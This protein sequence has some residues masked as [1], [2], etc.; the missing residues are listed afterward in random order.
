MPF[1]TQTSD[2]WG[3]YLRHNNRVV[4][5][6]LFD[7]GI[8]TF[9]SG[10]SN[11]T[12][13]FLKLTNV[14]PAMNGGFLRRWGVTAYNNTTVTTIQSPVR[15][16]FYNVP[17]DQSDPTNTTNTNLWIATD[18][19][20]FNTF[21]DTG[22]TYTGYGPTDFA[23][24]G[25]V[26]AL[27]SRQWFYY[28]NGVNAPRKVYPGYTTNNTDSLNGI[29][30][31]SVIGG[32]SS[33]Y[34]NWPSVSF[35]A[36]SG[37]TGWGYTSAPTV[38][39]SDIPGGSGHGCTISLTI[40]SN[41]AVIS[42][43]ITN[44]G[45][46]YTN[47]YA[48]VSA[49]PS[50]GTQA[51]ITLY[52]QQNSVASN[53]GSVLGAD[54]AGPMSFVVGRQ[55]G[56]A[57]QNSLTGHTSDVVMASDPYGNAITNLP[58]GPISGANYKALTE[59]YDS[60]VSINSSY[61]VYV[62]S[63]ST[64]GQEQTAGFT[65]LSVTV[66]VPGPSY[67]LD[68]QVDTVILLATSDGGD[69]GT[70]Y[71]VASIPLT[72]FTLTGGYYRYSY[73]DSLPDS[74]NNA[75]N[76]Y[77][78]TDT[79][80]ASNLW[81]ETDNTGATYGI[82]L[83]TPP[84]AAGFLYPTLHQGRMF[85]TDGKTVF[86]SKSLDEV[87]TS[88]GLITCKWEECWPGDYQLPVA[89]D[90]E[91]ILGLK[92]DGTNL[93]IG[94]DK[95]IFTLYGSDPSNFDIPS[96]AFA[97]T[98]I[99]SN[100]CWTVI[101]AEGQPSGFVW[102]TQ[103]LK[104]IHSDFSTYR[105][106]GT[107]I[108]VNLNAL[109]PSQV[110]FAKIVSLTQGPYNFVVFN[111]QVESNIHFTS[112]LGLWIWETR[113]GKWYFWEWPEGESGNTSGLIGTIFVYQVPAYSTSALPVGS[114]Y[115][116]YWRTPIAGT[117]LESRYFNPNATQD[118][119]TTNIPWSVKTSWQDLGDDT[120]IKVINEVELTGDDAPFTVSLYGATSQSQFDSGGT[121]LK[122]GASITGPISALGTNKFYAAGAPTGAKYYSLEIAP[123]NPGT[124][125]SVLSSFSMEYYPMARI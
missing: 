16:F 42:G 76:I 25:N 22:A 124:S 108:Y 1:N 68:P 10:P 31:P 47:A 6:H 93:H 2:F 79:L 30:I 49:P 112:S 101:Y 43:V 3:W 50:G 92:S 14:M 88:T 13:A 46:E 40:D 94:T 111:F 110:A 82:S 89:L 7:A 8:D 29:A 105:E 109:V 74:Y 113:L 41:G 37:G 95:S 56:V 91:T 70:L 103:D 67:E 83:N 81:A 15:T 120:A 9:T 117:P 27:T 107:P 35:S 32:T 78:V 114:K 39:V 99:L 115:L 65:Q 122:S 53:Y 18:N 24:S 45:D 20:H 57:L 123:V 36:N 34:S 69:V 48:T 59:I 97:Q 85:A 77:G 125:P 21:V 71:E 54:L 64:S 80:L 11:N 73:K 96:M 66:T 61:P 33:N 63:T 17:Q 5:K 86:F 121:L 90:N 118:F 55:Y 12:Q 75:T 106:I 84:T 52:T 116:F 19:Q 104:V 98:G 62:T 28:G 58:Y 102:I 60:P 72:D 44:S 100:D 26:N 51:Y 38:T 4:W 87:T 23:S 119:G